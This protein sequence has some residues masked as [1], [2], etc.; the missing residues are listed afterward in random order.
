[1]AVVKSHSLSPLIP[2]ENPITQVASQDHTANIKSVE[3]KSEHAPAMQKQR[4]SI[5]F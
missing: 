3:G 2:R 1:M 4:P 5:F